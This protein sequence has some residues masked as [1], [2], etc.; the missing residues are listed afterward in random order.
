MPFVFGRFQVNMRL[1]YLVYMQIR[2]NFKPLNYPLFIKKQVGL[3]TLLG[4]LLIGFL[5]VLFYLV[6]VIVNL[7]SQ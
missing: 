7:Q 4:K 2:S 3:L 6:F 5:F 1:I